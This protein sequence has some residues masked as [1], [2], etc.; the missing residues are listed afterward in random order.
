MSVHLS[1]FAVLALTSY[2]QLVLKAR[3]AVY[4]S[5]A[6]NSDMIRYL[7]AMFTDIWVLSAWTATVIGGC[8][9]MLAL[10]KNTL[11]YPYSFIALTFLIVP[12]GA[13]VF[14]GE[15]LPLVRIAGI[16]FIV[17][18]VVMSAVA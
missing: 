10:E 17:I 18:G 2:G 3:A 15:P 8:F 5:I 11:S 12:I 13:A 14:L 16:G 7:L 4:G 1:I 9:W 6:E